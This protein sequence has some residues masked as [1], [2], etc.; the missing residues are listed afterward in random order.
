MMQ[1]LF[2]IPYLDIPIYG[3]GL[4]LVIGFLAA[5]ELAKFLARRSRVNPEI[6]VNAGLIALVSGVIGARLSHVLENW[7]DYTRA[8]LSFAQNLWNAVN[9][10]SG[11]LTFYGGLILG[12]VCTLAYGIY[13]RIPVR[14]GMDIVAPTIMVGLAFGRIGCF[15]NGCCYGAE[16]NAP[17]AVEFPYYSNAYQE[18][19]DRG[20]IQPPPALLVPTARGGV[21]LVT[22]EELRRGYWE[23]Q[24]IAPDGQLTVK[25]VALPP[26]AQRL[27]RDTHSKELHPAQLYSSLDAFLVAA[28][29]VAYFTMPHAP[30]RVFA[31]MLLMMGPVRFLTEMVRAEP[32][33]MWVGSYGLS[34]SMVLS[35]FFVLTGTILWVGFGKVGSKAEWAEQ[36]GDP[37]LATS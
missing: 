37:Q 5:T 25:K 4:M 3:Y 1:E 14:V 15:L 13:K 16:C 2:R 11:G 35:I 8:D 20:E 29:L 34:F 32:P 18:Q 36:V 21:R 33:V 17:W 10:R 31:L 28:T 6:F 22:P 27:A 24:E 12:F 9:I 26:E 23:R 19:F 7:H 30:G